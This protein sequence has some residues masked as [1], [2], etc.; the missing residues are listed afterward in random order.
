[1]RIY[2]ASSSDSERYR[3]ALRALRAAGHQVYDWRHPRPGM[4]GVVAWGALADESRQWAPEASSVELA[5][6][7]LHHAKVREPFHMDMLALDECE[8]VVLVAPCGAANLAGG[9]A[10]GTG[11]MLYVL[12]PSDWRPELMYALAD[13]VCTSL[14]DLLETLG[15]H[16]QST[17]AFRE[18]P[19]GKPNC[20]QCGC[21]DEHACPGGCYWVEPGLCSACHERNKIVAA[22]LAEVAENC[23]WAEPLREDPR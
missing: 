10:V 23:D 1:V 14:A 4:S 22:Q 9:W 18:V 17:F 7:A 11:K 8:A 3:E 5:V 20:R 2:L 6:I 15:D 12:V 21:W 19:P 13:G 16:H